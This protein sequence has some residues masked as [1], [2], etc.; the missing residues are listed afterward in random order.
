MRLGLLRLLSENLM[1]VEEFCEDVILTVDP[2]ELP[3]QAKVTD[4]HS[5]V[6]GN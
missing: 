6:L 2:V 5:A 4:L 1:L 3:C